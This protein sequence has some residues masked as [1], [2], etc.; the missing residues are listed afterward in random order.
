MM[1]K[2]TYHATWDA[3]LLEEDMSKPGVGVGGDTLRQHLVEMA[4]PPSL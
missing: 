1:K 3:F 2:M 4:I